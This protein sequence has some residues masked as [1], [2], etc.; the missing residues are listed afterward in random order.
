MKNVKYEQYLI[1]NF[2]LN[3]FSA[4]CHLLAPHNTPR[5]SIKHYNTIFKIIIFIKCKGIH[6]KKKHMSNSVIYDNI[7]TVLASDLIPQAL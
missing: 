6:L 3:Y 2:T 5:N 4:F 7:N 1:L